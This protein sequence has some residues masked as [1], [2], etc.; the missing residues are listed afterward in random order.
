MNTFESLDQTIQEHIRQITKTSGLPDTPESLEQMAAAWLEKKKRFDEA[1]A[2]NNMEEVSF[3][4]KNESRGALVLTYS[5]SLIKLGPMNEEKRSVEYTAIGLRTDVP[6]S[7]QEEA[8]V[9][10]AD[11]ECDQSAQFDKGPIKTSSPVF[12]IAVAKEKMAL[13][14]EEAFL[15]QIT[16][17]IAEDFVEVNKTLIQ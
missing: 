13:D 11:V 14:E 6:E 9:L 8:S 17:D 15:T 1:L 7:A 2:D 10:G 4:E 3:F 5:G 16:Q 12:K